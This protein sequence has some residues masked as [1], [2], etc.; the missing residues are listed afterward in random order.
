[1]SVSRL[2]AAAL[3]AP[4][5]LGWTC[6]GFVL[7]ADFTFQGLYFAAERSISLLMNVLGPQ[8]PAPLVL[9]TKS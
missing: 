6:G 9:K 8:V 7:G 1:M 5:F 3:L 2:L 4:P